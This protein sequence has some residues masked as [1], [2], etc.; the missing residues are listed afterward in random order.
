M[1]DKNDFEPV[2]FRV[3]VP[4]RVRFRRYRSL[5]LAPPKRSRQ[6]GNTSLL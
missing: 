4:G 2:A 5:T 6:R 3:V 1:Q